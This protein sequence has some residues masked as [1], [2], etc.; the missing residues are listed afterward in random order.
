MGS[1]KAFGHATGLKEGKAQEDGIAH[2]PPD[3]SRQVIGCSDFLY[4][5]RINTDADHNE[6]CLEAKGNQ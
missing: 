3:G 2:A 5:H 4:Q 1:E 6:K